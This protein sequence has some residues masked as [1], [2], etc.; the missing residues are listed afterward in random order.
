VSVPAEY[1][2]VT[3]SVDPGALQTDANTILADVNEIVTALN[4]IGSTVGDLAL[5]WTGGSADDATDFSNRWTL[6][7]TAL[8][9]SDDG[10]NDGVMNQVINALLTASS[11]SGQ[12]E[13]SVSEM[14]NVL[15]MNATA[16]GAPSTPMVA[17]PRA[18]G[19]TPVNPD[20]T[21]IV[22]I[23]WAAAPGTTSVASNSPEAPN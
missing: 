10:S 23:G 4:T 12:T 22:E 21:A 3:M 8:F 7:M 2:A 15:N 20:L 14:F 9:G 17:A 13:M 6:A 11:N 5:S 1:N 18:A 19:E 16:A